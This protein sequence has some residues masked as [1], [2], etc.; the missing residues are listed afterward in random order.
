M[1]EELS[2]ARLAERLH[3]RKPSLYNQ[4]AGLGDLRRE[5]ALLGLRELRPSLSRA[6]VGKAGREGLFVL[7]EAYRAKLTQ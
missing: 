6:A 3:V 1:G 5:L 2:L 4:V 7:A